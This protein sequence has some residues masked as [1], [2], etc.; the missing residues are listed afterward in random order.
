MEYA[1]KFKIVLDELANAEVEDLHK[2]DESVTSVSE[3]EEYEEIRKL[4]E[5]VEQISEPVS[6]TFTLT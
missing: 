3:L 1:D 5:I 2:R 4:R 6:E